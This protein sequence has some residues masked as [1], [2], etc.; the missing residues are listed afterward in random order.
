MRTKGRQSPASK[1]RSSTTDS[2]RSGGRPKNHCR[3]CT[4]PREEDTQMR[5]PRHTPPREEAMQ[6]EIWTRGQKSHKSEG[7]S[8]QTLSPHEEGRPKHTQ[9]APEKQSP[10]A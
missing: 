3:R 4:P 2:T 10:P 6:A 8:M 7:R 5:W 9:K 1:G